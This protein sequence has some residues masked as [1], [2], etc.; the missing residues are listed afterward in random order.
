[1]VLGLSGA[2]SPAG[3]KVDYDPDVYFLRFRS[4]GWMEGTPAQSPE[5]DAAIR[6]AILREMRAGGL[7]LVEQK[8]DLIVMTHAAIGGPWALDPDNFFYGGYPQNG[9]GKSAGRGGEAVLL[10][11]ML[12]GESK[13]LIWRGMATGSMPRDPDEL[14]RKIDKVIRKMFRRFPPR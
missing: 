14:G 11:D 9:W 7:D 10:V 5:T 6:A 1:M 2:P 3:V 12:E 4:F 8:P 13:R